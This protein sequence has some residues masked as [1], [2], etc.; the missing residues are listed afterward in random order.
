MNPGIVTSFVIGGL[1]LLS[2]LAYNLNL[3]QSQQ[4]TTLST[5]N[6]YNIDQVVEILSNDIHHI[7]YDLG[8]SVSTLEEPVEAASNSKKLVYEYNNSGNTITWF[9]DPD[10]PYTNSSNP[11]DYYLYRIVDGTTTSWFPVTYFNVEYYRYNTLT[12]SWEVAS[13]R[14]LATRFEVEIIMESQEPIRSTKS[15]SNTY[16][17]TAW[18]KTFTPNN[19]NKPW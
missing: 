5:I 18:K 8:D 2:V 11:D 9:A 17:R 12:S 14:K 6:Q 7:G 16:H 13:N 1:M 15:G 19:I 3:S 10:A 4:E